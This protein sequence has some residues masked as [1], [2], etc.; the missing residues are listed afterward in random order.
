VRREVEKKICK[1]K[2]GMSKI[3]AIKEYIVAK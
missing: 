1:G 2:W 3:L